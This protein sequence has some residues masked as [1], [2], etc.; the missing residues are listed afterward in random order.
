MTLEDQILTAVARKNYQPLKPKALAR[1]LG[2]APLAVVPAL[3]AT[4]APLALHE[5]ATRLFHPNASRSA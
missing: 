5:A 4:A 2:V 3:A 1:Q